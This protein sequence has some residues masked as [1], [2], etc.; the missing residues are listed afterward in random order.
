[1]FSRIPRYFIQTNQSENTKT[2]YLHFVNLR[3]IICDYYEIE[4][5]L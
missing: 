5:T 4:A 2:F 1:M 3:K